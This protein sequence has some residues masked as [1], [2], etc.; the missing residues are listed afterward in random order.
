MYLKIRPI[1]KAK[2]TRN[3]WLRKGDLKATLMIYKYTKALF[4]GVC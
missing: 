2:G 4:P 1:Q 3:V